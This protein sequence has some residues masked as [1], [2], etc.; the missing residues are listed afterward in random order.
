MPFW[1]VLLL[2]ATCATVVADHADQQPPAAGHDPVPLASFEPYPWAGNET[3]AAGGRRLQSFVI[4][5]NT[6]AGVAQYTG[7]TYPYSTTQTV[8]LCF[9]RPDATTNIYQP[10]T[11]MVSLTRSQSTPNRDVIVQ[12]RGLLS[13]DNMPGTLISSQTTSVSLNTGG[14][15]TLSLSGYASLNGGASYYK[16][17]FVIYS[18]YSQ[19]S[20]WQY[21]Y[22]GGTAANVPTGVI[23]PDSVWTASAVAGP[24]TQSNAGWPSFFLQG[25]DLSASPTST[26]VSLPRSPKRALRAL[27]AD[28]GVIAGRLLRPCAA[29]ST[30]PSPRRR[31]LSVR[32]E[33]H[34]LRH[35]EHK[36]DS[37]GLPISQLL[38]EHHGLDHQHGERF[39]LDLG[40]SER[41]CQCLWQLDDYTQHQRVR[42]RQR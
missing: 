20:D 39:G 29:T 5:D 10:Q 22:A 35:G 27:G 41:V 40:V 8:A 1:V 33:P 6:A 28:R 23:T 37:H 16:Y 32:A 2:A 21:S 25:T 7:S 18:S 15:T 12:L 14:Y 42:L 4:T 30:P 19:Q 17:C 26:P 9:L 38:R 11:L 13:T 3:A 34:I 36:L 24:Y 31:C